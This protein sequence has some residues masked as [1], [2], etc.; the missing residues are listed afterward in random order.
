M[1]LCA[2]FQS[3][4]QCAGVYGLCNDVPKALRPENA[5][6]IQALCGQLPV[7]AFCVGRLCR[8]PETVAASYNPGAVVVNHLLDNTGLE[9][10]QVCVDG[11]DFRSQ[12]VP[13]FQKGLVGFH[14]VKQCHAVPLQ[15]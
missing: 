14:K 12:G 4:L 11:L 2:A 8:W 10:F 5:P 6:E 15:K 1:L 13:L 3:G 9:R 7:R